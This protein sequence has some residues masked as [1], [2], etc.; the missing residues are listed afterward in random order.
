MMW[1][2]VC[3]VVQENLQTKIRAA[4]EAGAAGGRDE[5]PDGGKHRSWN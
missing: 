4:A 2:G 5:T 1:F 3:R